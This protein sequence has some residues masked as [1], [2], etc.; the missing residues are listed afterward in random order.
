MW[1]GA[2]VLV[3]LVLLLFVVA[4]VLGGRGPGHIGRIK[5]FRLARRGLA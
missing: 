2:L 3:L 5:R 4:R 1:T